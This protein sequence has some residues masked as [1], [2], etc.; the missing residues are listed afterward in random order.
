MFYGYA[1]NVL[2]VNL[3]NGRISTQKINEELMKMYLG[4]R[5]FGIKFLFDELGAGID[6]FGIE[7]KIIF[8]IGPLTG[9]TV[10]SCSRYAIVTKSPLTGGC[11]VTMSGG[12]WP[13]ELKKAG[14]DAIIVEGS[15]DNPVYLWINDDHVELRDASKVYGLYTSNTER[16]IKDEVNDQKARVAA[17]GPAGENLV[18]YACVSNDLTSHRGGQAGRGGAGAVMGSKKLKAIAVRG[19]KQPIIK[20][21][22]SISK[23]VK[24]II[25]AQ[26]KTSPENAQ[27]KPIGIDI[28]V[29]KGVAP[30]HFS[31]H[32]TLGGLSVINELGI[33][34]TRNFQT[35]VFLDANKIEGSNVDDEVV[36]KHTA[37]YACPIRCS[38]I[39]AA[40]K[41]IYAG[42]L[43]DGPEY[44]TAWGFSGQCDNNDIN[45]VIAADYLV[46]NL[47]LDGISSGNVIGFVMELY[48]RGILTSKEADHLELN[49]GNTRTMIEL[50]RKIAYR[51]GFGNLLAEGVARAAE[52]I[53]RGADYYAMHSKGMELPAYDC[54]GAQAHGLAHATSNRGG[55]HERGYATQELFGVPYAVDRFSTDG[56]GELTKYNQ[57]RTAVF[58]SAI[59]CVF[60]SFNT[61]IEP[62][63]EALQKVTGFNEFE[64]EKNLLIIGERIWNIERAFNTREGMGRSDDSMPKRMLEEPMPEGPCKGQTLHLP[65]LLDQYYKARGWNIET[66]Y[67][68]R[69]KLQELNLSYV[70]DELEGIGRL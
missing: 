45:T 62:Y 46:D 7:N 15:S 52:S 33:F 1:G 32:G 50:V 22:T 19:T 11:L 23:T 39:R 28:D 17:I 56:K 44:E 3:S 31:K 54:R 35:G 6:P 2:R 65:I 43:T 47:G 60:S 49:W 40:R 51:E 41:G 24:K 42:Y 25:D 55:C 16:F 48:Q 13:A 59:V 12:W 69:E 36:V 53:G 61:G 9:T 20:E 30:L 64:T 37:C 14:Y 10:P 4:G 70:A 18:R 5:G 66:G 26:F 67:P 68:T 63:A 58:D 27:N 34:P 29:T 57:D 21:E 8:S 38:K